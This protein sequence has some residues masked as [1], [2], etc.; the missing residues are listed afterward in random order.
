MKFTAQQ[1][2]VAVIVITIFWIFFNFFSIFLNVNF[3]HIENDRDQSLRARRSCIN[4]LN[5]LVFFLLC[6]CYSKDGALMNTTSSPDY[7]AN[8]K[9][10][11]ELLWT[12]LLLCLLSFINV[13]LC[14]SILH[15]DRNNNTEDWLDKWISGTWF[16]VAV[17]VFIINVIM[18]ITIGYRLKKT[19]Q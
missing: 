3:G 2:Y 7:Q 18:F 5:I 1:V 17:V 12:L 8:K 10:L 6:F 13:L 9:I 15:Y 19:V 14:G 4:I 11:Y 16:L